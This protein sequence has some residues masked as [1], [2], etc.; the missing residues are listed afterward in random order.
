M[1]IL[2]KLRK[3]IYE[4]QWNDVAFLYSTY[5]HIIE[6]KTYVDSHTHNHNTVL[7]SF[8]TT[9]TALPKYIEDPETHRESGLPREF[10]DHKTYRGD[11]SGNGYH[12]R[13]QW[14]PGMGHGLNNDTQGEGWG[15]G[16][17][18][19]TT[20]QKLYT[21]Q[22]SPPDLEYGDGHGDGNGYGNGEGDGVPNNKHQHYQN[23]LHQFFVERWYPLANFDRDNHCTPFYY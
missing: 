1:N 4:Q 12:T 14:E 11:G 17:C 9:L 3:S 19:H 18:G 2:N 15:M 23:E 5:Q 16:E 10:S 21:S 13:C 20:V 8:D 6:I 22:D 7:E